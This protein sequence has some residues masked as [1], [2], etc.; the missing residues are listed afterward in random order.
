LRYAALLALRRRLAHGKLKIRNRKQKSWPVQN[1]P[2]VRKP[3]SASCQGPS[4]APGF[5]TERNQVSIYLHHP[6]S[7]RKR[8]LAAFSLYPFAPYLFELAALAL[9]GSAVLR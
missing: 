4:R 2:R 6:D 1:N 8:W 7:P 3:G 5:P 9:L